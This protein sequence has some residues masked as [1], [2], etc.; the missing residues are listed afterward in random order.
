MA[1]KRHPSPH[2]AKALP[3]PLDGRDMGAGFAHVLE[4]ILEIVAWGSVAQE[5]IVVEPQGGG[6]RPEPC[7]LARVEPVVGVAV[8]R[9][10]PLGRLLQQLPLVIAADSRQAER[11]QQVGGFRR[12]QRPGKDVAEID[13]AVAA[14]SPGIRQH[15]LQRGEVAVDVRQRGDA[16]QRSNLMPWASGSESE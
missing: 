6:Q 3:Y 9:A 11:H 1:A 2:V 13:D 4:E 10:H 5:D 7:A 15:R 16:H 8:G 12:P 14:A